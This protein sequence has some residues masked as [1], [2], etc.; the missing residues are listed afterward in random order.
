MKKIIDLSVH[1]LVDLSLRSGSIDERV[2]NQGTLSEGTLIHH[3]CGKR[4]C[5]LGNKPAY[6][7]RPYSEST[8]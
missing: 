1:Q 7:S 3:L 6:Q 4:S 5:S 2:F 8:L